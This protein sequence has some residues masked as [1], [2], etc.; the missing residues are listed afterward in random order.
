MRMSYK[1]I[2]LWDVDWMCVWNCVCMLDVVVMNVRAS[3][4]WRYES[5]VLLRYEDVAVREG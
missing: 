4:V 3:A 2:W 5:F 1:E